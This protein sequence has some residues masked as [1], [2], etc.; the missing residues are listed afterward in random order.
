MPFES[1]HASTIREETISSAVYDNTIPSMVLIN[2]EE[3]RSTTAL[4]M[5]LKQPEDNV[6]NYSWKNMENTNNDLIILSTNE[7]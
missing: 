5:L 1:R 6:N 4:K 7:N 2:N 3:E